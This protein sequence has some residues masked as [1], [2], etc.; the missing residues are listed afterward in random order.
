LKPSPDVIC[1]ELGNAGVLVHLGTNEIFELNVTGYRVWQ[2]LQEGL[3]R[4]GIESALLREF[5]VDPD[6][7]RREI[8]D[9]L[10]GLAAKH[11]IVDC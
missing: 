3:D 11:L 4:S 9:L 10:D 5:T 8:G 1:R 6:Q 7:L 2:L